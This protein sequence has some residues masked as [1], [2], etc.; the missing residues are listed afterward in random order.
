MTWAPSYTTASSLAHYMASDGYSVDR[1][2]EDLVELTNAAESGSRAVDWAAKRQFGLV[3]APEA[4]EYTLE[5]STTAGMWF[6][7]VD[8]FMTTSG[9]VLAFDSA[10]DGTYSTAIAN[11]YAVPARPNEVDKSK[12]YERIYFRTTV[13]VVFDGRYFGLRATIRWGWTAFPV[14]VVNATN[15]QSS[16]FFARRNSPYGV[17]GSPQDGS[18]VRLSARADPDVRVSLKPYRRVRWA[19]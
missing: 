6:A 12:P 16:R 19:A 17:A 2:Q 14:T 5:W 1:I 13:G 7:E 10:R 9:M 11:T 15:M 18:E 3:D 4:R 8:D